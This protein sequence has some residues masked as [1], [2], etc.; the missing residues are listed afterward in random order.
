[1]ALKGNAGGNATEL[2]FIGKG[3]YIEGNI[4]TESSLRV[5][6]IVKGKLICKNTLTLGENGEIEGD[7]EA[8]NAII[9]GKIKGK[10]L[11][12]DKLVLES[13][14]SLTGELKAKKLII[15]EGAV[16]DGTS[17]MGI[18]TPAAVKAGISKSESN[19]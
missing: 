7:V 11:V 19:A 8:A 9:G 13:K 3:T 6:G 14:S 18:N 2:N 10:I 12:G 15:D 16:F 4:K 1:M 5:D 17:D